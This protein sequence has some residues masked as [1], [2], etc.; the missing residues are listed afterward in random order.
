MKTLFSTTNIHASQAPNE[1]VHINK[2]AWIVWS[3][4]MMNMCALTWKAWLT[5]KQTV[6]IR[7][8]PKRKFV[9]LFECECADFNIVYIEHFSNEMR[10]YPQRGFKTRGDWYEENRDA[11]HRK[12]ENE[13]KK[14]PQT[15]AQY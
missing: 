8:F 5:Q 6:H 10:I 15:G 11:K 12:R 3:V 4:L 9:H 1:R 14:T 13:L 7:V 2:S